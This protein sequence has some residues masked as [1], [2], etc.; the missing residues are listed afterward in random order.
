MKRSLALAFCAVI[1]LIGPVLLAQDND[2]KTNGTA[3]IQADA[4]KDN[5]GKQVAITGKVA[6]VSKAEKIV[7]LNIDKAY[8]KQPFTAVIFAPNTNVFGDLDSLKGKTVEITGK[9]TDFRGHPQI[10]LTS[11]NQLKIVEEKSEKKSDEKK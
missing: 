11:T 4:A 8:P 7:R 10:V 2:S 3:K 9:I 5:I 1:S 6:E